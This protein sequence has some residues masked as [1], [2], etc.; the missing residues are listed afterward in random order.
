M[1]DVLKRITG[2]ATQGL[3]KVVCIGTGE[4]AGAVNV[5]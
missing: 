3:C 5:V 1:P 4:M 2:F